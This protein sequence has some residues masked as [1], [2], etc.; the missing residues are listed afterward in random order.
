LLILPDEDIYLI[1]G[2]HISQ[3]NVRYSGLIIH[4]KLGSNN[5][6]ARRVAMLGWQHCTENLIFWHFHLDFIR[7]MKDDVRE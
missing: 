7:K 2:S 4:L 1:H 6:D 5:K 3:P